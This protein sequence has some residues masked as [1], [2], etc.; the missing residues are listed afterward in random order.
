MYQISVDVSS[1]KS[2]ELWYGLIWFSDC[3]VLGTPVQVANLKQFMN[4]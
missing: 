2:S 4:I 1:E 3:S